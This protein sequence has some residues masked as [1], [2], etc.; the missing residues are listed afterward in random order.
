[1]GAGKS[2]AT[3]TPSWCEAAA[4]PELRR[5]YTRFSTLP[6][7]GDAD[8][9]SRARYCGQLAGPVGDGDR[10]YMREIQELDGVPRP[11]ASP[12]GG[13]RL[14]RARMYK[15]GARKT[16]HAR[17]LRRCAGRAGAQPSTVR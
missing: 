16:L 13:L 17:A 1:M 10:G 12:S 2:R 9:R 6:I 8:V 15:V 4:E 11:F 5:E 14:F 7:L 3:S